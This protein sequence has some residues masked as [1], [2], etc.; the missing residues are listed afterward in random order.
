MHG[1][2]LGTR[3]QLTVFRRLG[4]LQTA[5]HGIAH[6]RGQVRVLTIGLLSSAP[7]RVAEDVYIGCPYRQTTHFHILA[8]QVVKTVVVLCAELRRGHIETLI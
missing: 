6:H 1:I 3:P 7:P 2:V 4:A 5:H 8:A